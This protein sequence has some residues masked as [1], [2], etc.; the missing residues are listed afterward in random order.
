MVNV[1]SSTYK[2]ISLFR[3]KEQVNEQKMHEADSLVLSAYLEN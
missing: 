1:V 3:F 2:Y